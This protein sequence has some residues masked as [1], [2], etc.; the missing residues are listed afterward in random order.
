ML[1]NVFVSEQTLETKTYGVHTS[2]FR[3]KIPLCSAIDNQKLLLLL[4]VGLLSQLCVLKE[5]DFP[6]VLH[7]F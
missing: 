1:T 3:Q 5:L 2:R 6:M 4:M 7:G